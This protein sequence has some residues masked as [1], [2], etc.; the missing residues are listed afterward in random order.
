MA[1]KTGRIVDPGA[2]ILTVTSHEARHS[3]AGKTMQSRA[4]HSITRSRPLLKT[5]NPWRSRTK[6]RSGTRPSVLAV[7]ATAAL[8]S[9]A[10]VQVAGAQVPTGDG[11]VHVLLGAK[12]GK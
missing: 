4:S 1:G 3:P 6:R 8:V 12:E 7:I 5:A 2:L 10:S 9:L 11:K